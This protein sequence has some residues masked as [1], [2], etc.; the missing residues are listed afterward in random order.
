VPQS[1]TTYGYVA[2]WVAAF[3]S[4]FPNLIIDTPIEGS[5][6]ASPCLINDECDFSIIA[7]EMLLAEENNYRNA[8]GRDPFE[9]PVTGG[10]YNALAFTDAM[11]VFVHPTNPLSEISYAEFDAVWS[12]ERKRGYPRAITKWGQLK[13][14]ADYPEWADRDI[15]RYGVDSANGFAHFLNRTI[16]DGG[17]WV[18]GINAFPTVFLIATSVANHPYSFGYSGLAYLNASIKPLRIREQLDWPYL[19][20]EGRGVLYSRQTICDRTYP[21]NR[22]T[23]IYLNKQP[24]VP[25][26]PEI[27]EFIN[28]V[29]S[30]EGQKC[31][32]DD[33]I[34]MPLAVEVVSELRE[35]LY[36]ARIAC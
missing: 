22:L 32:E 7:R 4:Y 5:G 2:R 36:E 29:L 14:L 30:Y 11:T 23:Y 27:A 3:K 17:H 28:F 16:L 21:L 26:A 33:Q 13:G 9:M 20:A 19:R 35:R 15:V 1:D 24:C 12:K 8:F 10:S 18:D 34:F 31:V 6:I 25:I